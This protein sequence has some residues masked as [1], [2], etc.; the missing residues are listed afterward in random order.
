MTLALLATRDGRLVVSRE[1]R[2]AAA[3]FGGLIAAAVACVIV[4]SVT[5][6]HLYIVSF[7]F[8]VF[9]LAAGNVDSLAERRRKVMYAAAAALVLTAVVEIAIV[10]AGGGYHAQIVPAAVLIFGAA[11][12]LWYVRLA[13]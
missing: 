9:A 3:L 8:V 12:C 10:A 1:S 6:P 7:G 2:I 4:G 5:D 13:S 11:A